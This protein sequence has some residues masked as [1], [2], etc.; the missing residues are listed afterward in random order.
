MKKKMGRPTK[1]IDPVQ[2]EKLCEMMCTKK[3]I[4]SF[5]NLS[6]DTIE[7]WCKKTYKQ[8]FAV[9]YDQKSDKGRIA[10]RRV[11]LQKAK[12][13]NITMLIWLGKQWLGQSE[14]VEEKVTQEVKQ[15]ITYTTEWASKLPDEGNA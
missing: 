13:G 3:E 15:E 6:E 8:T 9:T 4:A 5:F 7:R 11:Q 2:F 14:K 12:E 1:D 10:I